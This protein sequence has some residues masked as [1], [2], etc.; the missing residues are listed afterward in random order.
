MWVSGMTQV[1]S[2]GALT[3]ASLASR[4]SQ[5]EEDNSGPEMIPREE[6]PKVLR[7]PRGPNDYPLTEEV[8]VEL[9]PEGHLCVCL[10]V[11]EE[12]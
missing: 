12:R 3:R 6:Q 10:W 1:L 9:G 2:N 8:T 4:V 5:S 7:K 11:W